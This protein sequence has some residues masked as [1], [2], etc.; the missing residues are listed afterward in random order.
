MTLTEVLVSTGIGGVV[1]AA[2]ASLSFYSARSLAGVSNY[3]QLDQQS[4]NALDTMSLRIRTATRLTSYSTN[5]LTF[6]Y[7]GGTLSYRF[8]DRDKKLYQTLNGN[9]TALLEDC[10]TLTFTVFQRNVASNTFNQFIASGTNDAKSVMLNWMCRKTVL[11]LANTESIQ[12]A[13]I[14]VRNNP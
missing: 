7:E 9:T 13:R 5:H 3:T 11:N 10:E 14:V 2:V 1:L 8:S 12:S 4:R 6:D